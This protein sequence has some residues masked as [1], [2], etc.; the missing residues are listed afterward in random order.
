MAIQLELCLLLT[1][2]CQITVVLEFGYFSKNLPL[3]VRAAIL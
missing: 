2:L 3:W 1:L